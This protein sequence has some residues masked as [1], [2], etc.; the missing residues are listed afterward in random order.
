MKLEW[1]YGSVER[2]IPISRESRNNLP[3]LPVIGAEA[4]VTPFAVYL[5][6]VLVDL[7]PVPSIRGNV[8]IARTDVPGTGFGVLGNHGG[9]SCVG[10][11][12]GSRVGGG[13]ISTAS[14]FGALELF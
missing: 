7:S 8:N 6:I 3:Q 1:V 13:G 11:A 9:P 14:D 2:F 10:A 12:S 4:R 5:L